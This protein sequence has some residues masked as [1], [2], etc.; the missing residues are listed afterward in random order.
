MEHQAQKETKTCLPQQDFFKRYGGSAPENYQRFFVPSIGAPLAADLIEVAALRPGER[1]LDVACGTGMVT[2]LAKEHVGS[3]YVAGLDVN[4]GMLAVARNATPNGM[5]I[6][7]HEASA[8]SMP[9]PNDAFD[10]VLCQLGLQFI[11]DKGAALREMQ[12]VLSPG[13]RLILSVVGPIPR[14]FAVL[15]EALAREVSAQISAF[16]PLVFSLHDAGSLERLMTE[17]GFREAAARSHAKRLRLPGPAEFLWQ[18]V[19]STPLS[20]AVAQVSDEKRYALERHVV[21]E[22]QTFVEDGGV[23]CPLDVVVCTAHK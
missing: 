2:R 18:Y 23:S 16:V 3:G 10:V 4:P 19:R 7:W 5:S 1:V 22:W 8:E 21:A 11:P 13:G 17:A 15:A 12:R 14:V 6:A 20:A 9:L